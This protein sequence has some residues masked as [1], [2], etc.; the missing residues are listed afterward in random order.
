MST[1]MQTQIPRSVQFRLTALKW[2][3][4]SYVVLESLAIVTIW[5]GVTFWQCVS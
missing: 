3:I 4:R 5:L 2:S 1:P